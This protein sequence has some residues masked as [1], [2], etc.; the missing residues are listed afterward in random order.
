[1]AEV[2]VAEIR[3]AEVCP[4][5]VRSAEGCTHKGVRSICQ[6]A[7]EPLHRILSP[8]R[9]RTPRAGER[10]FMAASFFLP[11]PPKRLSSLLTI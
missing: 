1:M 7:M 2:R 8:G 3:L 11:L 6:L 5:E 4:D 10:A 9:K